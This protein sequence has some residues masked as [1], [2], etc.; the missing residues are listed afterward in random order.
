ML[1]KTLIDDRHFVASGTAAHKATQIRCEPLNQKRHLVLMRNRQNLRNEGRV[2]LVEFVCDLIQ[3]VLK[4]I[5]FT[6]PGILLSDGVLDRLIAKRYR[7]ASLCKLVPVSCRTRRTSS[8]PTPSSP[9][10][11]MTLACISFRSFS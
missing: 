2:S 5:Q 1:L 7:L 11:A 3:P 6:P 4:I 10:A 9:T 8:T